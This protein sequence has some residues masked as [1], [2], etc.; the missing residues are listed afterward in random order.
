MAR[1]VLLYSRGPHVRAAL[2]LLRETFP[3]A[4][5]CLFAPAG[6]PREISALA[7][8][9]VAV[10]PP[11]RLSDAVRTLLLVR[12][13]CPDHFAVM[14]PSARLSL[15]ALLSGS[16]NRWVIAPDVKLVPLNANPLRWLWKTILDRIQGELTYRRIRREIRRTGAFK[17]RDH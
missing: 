8:R 6:F 14:F 10:P 9:H 4:E 5:L 16:A 7:D 13:Y 17:S 11:Q 1:A 2:R 15:F 3:D 12:Q